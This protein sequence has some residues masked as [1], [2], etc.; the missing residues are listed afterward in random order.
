VGVVEFGYGDVDQVFEAAAHV[1][2]ADVRIGRHSGTPLEPRGLVAEYDRDTGLTIWGAAKVPHFTRR[3]LAGMLGLAEHRIHVLETDAG[4]SFGIR[5]EFYPEDLLVPYLARLTGRPVKWSEDRYEHLVAANHAREQ[6]HCIELALDADGRL[7]GLRDE[8]WL[9]NGG[10]IRTHGAVVAVLTAAMMAG[11]YRLPACRT[12]VHIITT[13]K[14]PIGT[15]RA[16]GRFQNTFVREHALDVAA[17][18]LGMDPD[19]LRRINLLDAKDLPH[20]RP[21][22]VFGD[23]MVLDGAD[24]RAHFDKA[25]ETVGYPGW[26]AQARAAR[27]AG[28]LVGAGSAV[29]LEKA[30]LGYDTAV[31]EVDITGTVRVA[32][33]GATVGQGIETVLAQIVGDEF[34]LP[35]AS[36][37]VVLSDTNILPH[38]GGTFGS[39]STVVGGSSALLAA[40]EVVTKAKR[41]A[42]EM[43]GVGTQNLQVREGAVAVLEDPDRRVTF[44]EIVAECLTP[45]QIRDGE[46]PGLIGRST[47]VAKGMTYPYG[48]HFAQ[49]EIDPGTGGVRVL[50]Y[51]MTYEVGRAINPAM[52]RGQLIGGTVQGIGGALYEEF[53]YDDRGHPLTTSLTEYEWPRAADLP[54]IQVAVFEDAPAPGNPLR[55]RGAGEGGTAGPGG[56]LANAVR[57]ALQ[58]SG[59]VGSLPLHPER[60]R[61]LLR[62]QRDGPR[63]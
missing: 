20:R 39:R 23:P 24:H 45:Q 26:R 37:L 50:N 27:E 49:V 12:R 22:S 55:V 62:G 41:V 38:G 34:D 52:V 3:V 11:P 53:L 28:R 6:E 8:A 32:S 58:L 9:D 30:G 7:L 40:R 29:I 18:Q 4:G 63:V 57:D 35:P 47:Y 5:G 59:T 2:R 31:V 56:A 25:L 51:A 14:T 43:L 19:E 1:V 44:A 21:I 60:I 46:E 13:N 17:G 42:G 33:G 36:V 16:P 48:V 15:Y 61:S 10:Y 54:D